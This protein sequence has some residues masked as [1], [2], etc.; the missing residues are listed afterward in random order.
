MKNKIISIIVPIFNTEIY[1]SRCINSLIKQSY[2]NIEIVLVD[3]GSNDQSGKICDYYAKIDS[4]V[5]VF[6]KENEGVARTRNYGIS[7]CKGDY[8]TFVDADDFVSDKYVEKLFNAMESTQAQIS[9]CSFVPFIQNKH[10]NKHKNKK[11]MFEVFDSKTAL[12][13][14]LYGQKIDC[15]FWAKMYSKNI[16]KGVIIS[17]YKIFEDLDTMYK[18]ILNSKK[19]VTINDE[20]YFYFIHNK[21]LI[22]SSFDHNNLKILEILSKME[23][24]ID[25]KEF[26]MP[27][28]SRKIDACFYIIRNTDYK[29]I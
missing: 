5:N 22:H 2:K 18:L 23:N 7:H 9:I 19:I 6:H 20:L 27:L 11:N 28:L 25:M 4:R 13:N 16:F 29:R 24:N 21:S 26:E 12:K 8:I 17:D 15:S 3:D 14:L 1:L 10:K